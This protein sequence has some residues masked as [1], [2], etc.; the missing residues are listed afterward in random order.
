M[1]A[2]G[3]VPQDIYLIEG[4]IKSNIAVEE[5]ANIDEEKNNINTKKVN[6][7]DFVSKEYLGLNTSVGERGI[8]LSGGQTKNWYCKGSY[9]NPKIIIFDEATSSLDIENVK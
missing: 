3:Y 1:T 8:K 4:T 9:K 5:D 6:L 2:I 7:Y